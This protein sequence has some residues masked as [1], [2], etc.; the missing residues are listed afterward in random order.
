MAAVGLAVLALP[1]A[2]VALAVMVVDGRLWPFFR[3]TRIGLHGRPFRICKFRTM[4]DE[5]ASLAACGC[6]SLATADGSGG[7]SSL[8][9]DDC[10]GALRAPRSADGAGR[11]ECLGTFDH[12]ENA[13]CAEDAA[14]ERARR[15]EH[16]LP[17]E[18][19][20][21]RLGRWLRRTKLDELPELWNVLVGDMS[22][23]GPRPD[24]PGYAD[25]LTG[26]DR[27]IL[28]LRPGI[29]CEASIKYANEE[30]LLAQQPDPLKYNDEVI[31]PDK[32]RMN[33]EYYRNHTFWGDIRIIWRTIFR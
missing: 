31:Y 20:V 24:V 1:M 22:F 11:S 3:Q 9:D 19:R 27:L 28:E 15:L 2:A 5:D 6:R 21:T 10:G 29:T 14:A 7:C 17:N 23:V 4:R 8:A 16:V 33:L 26:D 13:G 25:R 30:Q 12:L 18:Q 32:V